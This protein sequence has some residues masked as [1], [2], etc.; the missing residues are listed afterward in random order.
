[1]SS[2]QIPRFTRPLNALTDFSANQYLYVKDDGSGNLALAG[3]ATGEVGAGFL[4]NAPGEGQMSEIASI[5]GGAQGKAGAVISGP[6]VELKAEAT[7][8]LSPATV[9]GDIVVAISK[10]AA[11]I[12]VVLEVEPVLYTK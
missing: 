4:H 12:N 3:S 6:G 5:G 11:A 10:Q 7:G 1:M 8:L 2:Y 9:A